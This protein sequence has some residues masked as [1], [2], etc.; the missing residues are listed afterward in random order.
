MLRVHNWS[1]AVVL[2][3]QLLVTDFMR[4]V[5]ELDER[6]KVVKPDP[7]AGQMMG[8]M[9]NAEMRGQYLYK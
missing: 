8:M 4:A 3:V 9:S 1:Y 6:L 5:L 7:T 2:Q